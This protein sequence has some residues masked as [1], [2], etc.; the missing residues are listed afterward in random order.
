MPLRRAEVR[1]DAPAAE[2][3]LVG[4]ELLDR[5]D[6]I[7]EPDGLGLKRLQMAVIHDDP[8]FLVDGGVVPD[9]LD[10]FGVAELLCDRDVIEAQLA[11][12]S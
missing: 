12:G 4:L 11:A 5:L 10:P 8:V 6:L 2:R 1:I 7:D 3:R 9:E